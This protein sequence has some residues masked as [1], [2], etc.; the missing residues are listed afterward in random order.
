MDVPS[1]GEYRRGAP[2]AISLFFVYKAGVFALGFWTWL[3]VLAAKGAP[4][5]GWMVV[6]GVGAATTTLVGVVLGVRIALARN[7]I[8]RH[9]QIMKSLVELSWYSFVKSSAPEPESRPTASDAE[10]LRFSND[11][12]P[13]NRH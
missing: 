11:P 6:A 5:S 10:V 1:P 2:G 3:A 7:A 12:R 4:V 8:D 9:E 13:R